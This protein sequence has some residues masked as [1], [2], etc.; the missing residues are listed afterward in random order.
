MLEN[1]KS[2]G[3]Y[4]G[5]N[6]EDET[7]G[8]QQVTQKEI[9][10]LAGIIDGE[11]YLGLRWQKDKRKWHQNPFA[12]PEMSITNT[13]MEIIEKAVMIIRK[14]GVNMFRRDIKWKGNNKIIHICQTKHLT[15]MLKILKPIINELTGNKR[16]RAEYI[17]EFCESRLEREL[18]RK[19]EGIGRER[20]GAIKPYNKRE[21]ELVQLCQPLMKRGTSTTIR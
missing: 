15:N 4:Q 19:T 10:W 9:G 21:K 2:F 17:I 5:E 7:I 16:K 3:C 12:R 11:G 8:N 18:E 14:L 6:P 20:S 1:H 13:D